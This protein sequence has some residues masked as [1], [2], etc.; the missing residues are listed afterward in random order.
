MLEQGSTCILIVLDT[1][2][3][4]T[5]CASCQLHPNKYMLSSVGNGPPLPDSCNR[6]VSYLKGTID[7]R[8]LI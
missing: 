8:Y 4:M 1:H 5:V 3:Y 7:C 2:S 6:T